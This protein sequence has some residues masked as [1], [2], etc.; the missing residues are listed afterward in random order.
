MGI[1]QELLDRAIEQCDASDECDWLL[2][3]L[4]P[5]ESECIESRYYQGMTRKEI[6]SVFGVSVTRVN[7]IEEKAL[8]KMRRKA[9][10]EAEWKKTVNRVKKNG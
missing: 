6:G 8:R 4:T 10:D 5:R 9:E 2:Q 1:D 3:F 7:H